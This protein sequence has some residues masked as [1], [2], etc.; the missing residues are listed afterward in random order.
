MDDSTTLDPNGAS[1]AL[2]E[3]AMFELQASA[4]AVWTRATRLHV[5][6][7]PAFTL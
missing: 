2:L 4:W 6:Y 7:T 3:H 5:A 1:A